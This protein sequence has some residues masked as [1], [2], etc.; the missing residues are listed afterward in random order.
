[1][2]TKN[3]TP[4]KKSRTDEQKRDRRDAYLRDT[5]GIG[6]LDFERI[7]AKQGNTCAICHS[8][9]HTEKMVVDAPGPFVHGILCLRCLAC[10]RA[11]R[12]YAANWALEV[13]VDLYLENTQ[14]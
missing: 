13:Q 7:L 9:R 1:M 5:Y 14:K 12:E 2:Q 11:K 6:L 10:V 3:T 8:S 4:S